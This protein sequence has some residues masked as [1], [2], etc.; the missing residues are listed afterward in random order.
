[1]TIRTDAAFEQFAGWLRAWHCCGAAATAALEIP[2]QHFDIYF[3]AKP[4]VPTLISLHC[5]CSL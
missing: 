2:L 4:V 3:P 5:Q 1:M